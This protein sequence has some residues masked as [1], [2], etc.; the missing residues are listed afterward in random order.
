MRRNIPGRLRGIAQHDQGTAHIEL[1][2]VRNKNR[3][4]VKDARYFGGFAL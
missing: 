2:K 3:E 4:Q 1:R